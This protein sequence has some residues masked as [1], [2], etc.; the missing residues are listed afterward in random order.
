MTIELQVIGYVFGACSLLL[1]VIVVP[2]YAVKHVGPGKQPPLPTGKVGIEGF[3]L[4]DLVGISLFLGLYAVNW[5]VATT[6]TEDP[7]ALLKLSS[8]ELQTQLASMIVL[9]AFMIGIVVVLLFW[10]LNVLE[11]W[12]TRWKKWPWVLLLA[13]ASVVFIW[14]VVL[15]L[16]NSPLND[17]FRDSLGEGKDGQQVSVKILQNVDYGSFA[18]MA[19]IACIG[20][21][22]S[23]EIIFRGYLYPAM[24][25]FSN[26]PV[27]IVFTGLLF[28]AVHMNLLGLIP[29]AIFGMLLAV[30]YE[31]TGSLWAPIAAHMLFNS[32][33]VFVQLLG[34]LNPELLEEAQ[35]HAAFIGVG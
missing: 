24:K 33:T 8:G 13:P 25:R 22:L 2:L 19:V 1:F 16:E 14:Q 32:A 10:R 4:L 20:A 11:L 23:E 35:K 29:L 31:I 30:L 18:L 5:K 9:Q 27:A 28:G 26:I 34:R 7:E 21:P 6:S 12:G 17:W 3:G 15:L